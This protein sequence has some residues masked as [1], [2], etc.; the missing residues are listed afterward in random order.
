VTDEE[1]L[2][3]K[4]GR[5]E[6]LHAGATTEGERDA[7]A[8]ARARIQ[9]KLRSLS[10]SSPPEEFQLSVPDPWSRKLLLALLRRYELKPYRRAGQRH[11]TVMVKVPKRFL[12]ETLW[13]E[14]TQLSETLG[15]YLAEV[16]DRVI[17]QAVDKDISEAVEVKQLAAGP[18]LGR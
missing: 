12:D 16:T 13:P 1:R 9:E 7:A 8:N 18:G 5:I 2:L 17:A 4:L 15:T 6:A 10:A 3:E 11:S 14:F